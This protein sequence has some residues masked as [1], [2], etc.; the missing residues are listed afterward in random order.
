[1]KTNEIRV[2]TRNTE[3]TF[4]LGKQLV[5]ALG[6]GDIVALYGELGSGKTVFVRGAC[7]ALGIENQVRSPS[8]MLMQK[9]TG[10]LPVYHFDF[11]RI[12]SEVEIEA[13]DIEDYFYGEGISFIEWPEM[14]EFL[15]PESTFKLVFKR[16][17]KNNTVEKGVRIITITVPGNR[18]ISGNES[19]GH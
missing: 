12:S 5:S 13:L 6:K 8:F 2:T 4:Q 1:M 16:S 14:A 19:F 9:Y 3:E 15:L 18:R 11:Y 10:R 17:M 7:S